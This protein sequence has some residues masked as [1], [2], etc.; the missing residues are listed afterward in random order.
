MQYLL[1]YLYNYIHVIPMCIQAYNY[2]WHCVLLQFKKKSIPADTIIILL[3]MMIIYEYLLNYVSI[4]ISVSSANIH[5][6]NKSSILLLVSYFV[7][8]ARRHR[9]RLVSTHAQSVLVRA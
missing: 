5:M 3:I 9:F 6:A 2:T 4:C 8:F 7:L 1:L